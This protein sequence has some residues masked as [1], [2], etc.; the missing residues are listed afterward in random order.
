MERGEDIAGRCLWCGQVH[1]DLRAMPHLRAYEG[2]VVPTHAPIRGCPEHTEHVHAYLVRVARNSRWTLLAS[3]VAVLLVIGGGMAGVD[4]VIAA[5][6]LVLG[7]GILR[8]PYCSPETVR[9][10]GAV[11]AIQLARIIGVAVTVTAA[12]G[13]AYTILA[14]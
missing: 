8:F 1:D 13:L 12:G 5:G 14:A 7:A 2:V 10:L 9:R 11:R 4:V 6:M 3:V